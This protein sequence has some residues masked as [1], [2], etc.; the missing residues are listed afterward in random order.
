MILLQILHNA[1]VAEHKPVKETPCMYSGLYVCVS[2]QQKAYANIQYKH[3]QNVYFVILHT[4]LG[5]MFQI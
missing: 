3:L 1:A 5:L 2:Q 4:S